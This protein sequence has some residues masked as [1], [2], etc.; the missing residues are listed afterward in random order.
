MKVCTKTKVLFASVAVLMLVILCLGFVPSVAFAETGAGSEFTLRKVNANNFVYSAD[1]ADL[2]QAKKVGLVFGVSDD[3]S[4][5]WV[6]CANVEDGKVELQSKDTV[7]KSAQ[8]DIA[9][10][11]LSLTVVVN[12][13]IVKVFVDGSDVAVITCKLDG[14]EGGKVGV[15]KADCTVANEQFASTDTLN[16]DIFC[17][18]YSVVKVINITDGHYKLNS[19]EYSV[20]NGVLTV[21][22]EYLKTLE[23]DTVYT[24]RVVTSFTDL[25]FNITTDFTPAT[26]ISVRNKYYR[27]SDVAFDLSGSAVVHKLLIDGKEVE[28]TQTGGRVVISSETIDTLSSGQHTAKLYTDIGRPEATFTVSER[29]ETLTEIE[30]EA[31]HTFFWI[32]IAIFAALILAYVAF[33]VVQKSKKK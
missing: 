23:A 3:L 10:Q 16:G 19:S 27:G 2:S 9:A 33:T 31:T 21:S 11:Q 17:N 6:A 13:G 1:F 5:Y 26:A 14:Y 7:L 29:L 24:F 25:D 12:E 22:P 28:F 8:Y 30:P 20:K 4:S 18:G 32:D 15:L